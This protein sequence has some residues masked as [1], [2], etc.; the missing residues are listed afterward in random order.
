MVTAEGLRSIA[1]YADGVGPEKPLVL[2]VAENG[3]LGPPTDIVAR[4]HAV[5]LV[6]HVWTLRAD[7]E[8]LPAAYRGD[9]AAE[10]LRFRDLGVD[11]L[12]TDHPDVAVRALRPTGGRDR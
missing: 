3:R 2:P 5:G 7:A 11:G 4:A 12:F 1:G 6:V 10:V 8:F 9:A